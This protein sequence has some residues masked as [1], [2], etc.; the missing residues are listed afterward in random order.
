VIRHALPA[1]ARRLAEINHAAWVEAYGHIFSAALL[2]KEA[3][4]DAVNTT[5]D[6]WLERLADP[7]AD[8]GMT[9]FVAEDD[10]EVV[11]WIRVGPSHDDADVGEVHGIYVDPHR[12]RGRIG[13]SLMEAG[14]E[15]LRTAGFSTAVLWVLEENGRARRFY[16]RVGWLSDGTVRHSRFDGE[17]ATETRYRRKL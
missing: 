3:Q 2:A 5:A 13:T 8:P 14:L 4:E 12:W 11:G 1:D 9:T 16:E 10:G 15:L 7:S 17:H 6:M